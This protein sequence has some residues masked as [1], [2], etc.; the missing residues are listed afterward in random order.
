MACG[1]GRWAPGTC[2]A[3]MS[4]FTGVQLLT[5]AITAGTVALAEVGAG[6]WALALLCYSWRVGRR[7]GRGDG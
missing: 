1:H 3:P 5:L 2:G 7:H 4:F 6:W